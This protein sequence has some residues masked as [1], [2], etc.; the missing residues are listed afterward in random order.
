MKRFTCA[1]GAAIFAMLLTGCS[2]MAPQYP[3][4]LDNVAVLKKEAGAAA[5]VAAF[6][7]S[8]NKDNANP[9]SLRGTSLNSPY[10]GSYANYLSE[11][12]KQE[13]SL[14]GKYAPDSAI[15]ISGTLLKNDLD[16]SGFSTGHGQ[17]EARVVVKNRGTVQYDKVKSAQYEWD[18]HFVGAI[19]IPNA[20]AAYPNLVSKLLATLYADPDFISTLK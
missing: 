18:S 5:K 4:S 15:E 19:A 7:A 16:A 12:L 6:D 17:I 3:S 11:A 8:P 1:L 13:L 9:I 2:T 14:A 20:T 10:Q